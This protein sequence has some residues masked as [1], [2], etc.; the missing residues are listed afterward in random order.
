MQG[1]QN[2]LGQGVNPAT[3]ILVEI[4]E[5][6]PSPALKLLKLAPER[7]SNLPMVLL[8]IGVGITHPCSLRFRA[9][10]RSENP[11]GQWQCGGHN[12]PP[13]VEIRQREQFS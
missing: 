4:V 2:L 6:K 9:L 8:C 12:M 13:L 7:F 1:H 5:A 10:G 11:G 3:Q